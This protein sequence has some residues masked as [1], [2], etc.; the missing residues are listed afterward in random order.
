MHTQSSCQGS[1]A[2]T[3]VVGSPLGP[4]GL[5]TA[6]RG[7]TAISGCQH[8]FMNPF[9]I[10]KYCRTVGKGQQHCSGAAEAASGARPALLAP[11]RFLRRRDGNG[12]LDRS[13]GENKR[14]RGASI[15]SFHVPSVAGRRE[16]PYGLC[17]ARITHPH[18]YARI[19][20]R[21][22][23]SHPTLNRQVAIAMEKGEQRITVDPIPYFGNDPTIVSLNGSF[24]FQ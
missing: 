7:R 21:A 23:S 19:S 12:E 10:R 11:A 22:S 1:P 6:G 5:E 15:L 14:R 17:R 13:L 20:S 24:Q 3:A 9:R 2:I 16:D 4:F 8:C 18:C